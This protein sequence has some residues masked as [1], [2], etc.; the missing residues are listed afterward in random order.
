MKNT[1][2]KSIEARSQPQ[3]AAFQVPTPRELNE[4]GIPLTV[5]MVDAEASIEDLRKADVAVCNLNL[6]MLYKAWDTVYTSGQAIELANAT[7]NMCAKR[8]ML[9]NK[10][11][12]DTTTPMKSINSSLVPI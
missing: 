9:L 7:V 4:L 11:V 2:E 1:K 5:Q 10:P 3:P 6:L 12:G 8:R